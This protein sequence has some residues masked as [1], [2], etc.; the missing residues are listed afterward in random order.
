MTAEPTP[1]PAHPDPSHP[2]TVLLID[3]DGTVT[4]SFPGITASFRHAIDAMGAAA[5][6]E[7]FLADVV[8]P[9]LLDSMRAYGF[10][11]D[12]AER[13]VRAYRERYDMIGW[14]ENSVYA[15][16]AELLADLAAR[17]RTLA[18]AT[19]KNEEMARLILD[20]FGLTDHFAFI[21]GASADG[22]RR[23]KAQ[24]IARALNALDLDPSTTPIVMIGDRSHDVVG[25]AS[26][27]L[28]T[29]A[30][31]WG[32]ARPGEVDEAMWTVSTVPKLREVLGV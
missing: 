5:P 15:G 13:A 25:A 12:D 26:F 9:P 24:V 1:A 22:T 21:A 10:S 23:S 6:S 2:D 28:G 16:M 8:G 19:S 18:I 31:A 20:H 14:K 30:V 17:G 32:Y 3:L 11:D 29:I 27:G 4:D 7:E